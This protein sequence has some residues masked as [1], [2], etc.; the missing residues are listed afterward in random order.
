MLVSGL[1]SKASFISRVSVRC[2]GLFLTWLGHDHH[3]RTTAHMTSFY[4]FQFLDQLL[5]LC[6]SSRHM[7]IR[8][9]P[10]VEALLLFKIGKVLS[11]QNAVIL[12]LARILP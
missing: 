2:L 1:K 5:L 9:R 4:L 3:V 12:D 10:S 8:F 6:F 11:L 7:R